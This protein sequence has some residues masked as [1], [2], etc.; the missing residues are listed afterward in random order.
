MEEFFANITKFIE[1][2]AAVVRSM[3][4]AIKG[5]VESVA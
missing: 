2:F 1:G 5:I 4:A 3:I